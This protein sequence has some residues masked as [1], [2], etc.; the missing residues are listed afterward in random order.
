MYNIHKHMLMEGDHR[1]INTTLFKNTHLI[2]LQTR[3]RIHHYLIFYPFVQ[4][5]LIKK[6]IAVHRNTED[7]INTT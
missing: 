4:M 5:N 1:N 3:I 7:M 6:G 2:N